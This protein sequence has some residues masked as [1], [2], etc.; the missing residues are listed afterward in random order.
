MLFQSLTVQRFSSSRQLLQCP[1]QPVL[2]SNIKVK[3]AHSAAKLGTKT[4]PEVHCKSTVDSL[5]DNA[6]LQL[7]GEQPYEPRKKKYLQLLF[8]LFHFVLFS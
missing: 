3:S 8:N 7:S 5:T 4:S 1:R 2:K 6:N